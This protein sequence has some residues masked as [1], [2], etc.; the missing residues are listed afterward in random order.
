MHTDDQSPTA[1]FANLGRRI[2][3]RLLALYGVEAERATEQQIYAAISS[4]LRE[5][6]MRGWAQ[7]RRRHDAGGQRKVYY[8]SVEFLIGRNLNNA[9]CNLGIEDEIRS[10]LEPLGLDYD[11]LR[12]IEH[13]PGLGNGGLGRLAA[14]FLDSM[15]T[16]GLPGFGYGIRYDYGIF[17]Q[18]IGEQGEQTESPSEWLKFRNGWEVGRDDLRYTVPFGGRLTDDEERRWVDP[19]LVTAQ[20]Y[21]TPIPGDGGETVNYLRLWSGTAKEPFDLELFNAGRFEEAVAAQIEAKNLSRVLYP[22]DST[23]RG[24]ELRVRQQYFFVSASLQDILAK[25]AALGHPPA[26]LHHHAA[27]QLND[28]HPALAIPEL[29]RLLMD[30][31]GMDWD[32]AWEVT[33]QVFSYTNHTLLP[34][35]LES[36]PVAFFERLLPRHL[37][38]IYRINSE[39]LA[40]VDARFGAGDRRHRDMSLIEEGNGRRVRMS[41]L[42]IVGS[43]AVNGVAELHS[44]LMRETIFRDFYELYPD[45]FTNVTNGITPRRWLRQA[46]P[47]LSSLISS[48]IGECG[49]QRDLRLLRGLEQ[50]LEESEFREQFRAV[51]LA[52]K[53]RLARFLGAELEIAVDPASLF[54]AQI[55][56]IHEY[57]RQLLNL[58]HVIHRYNRIR[59]GRTEGMVPRTVIFSGKAA[60][61]YVMAKKIVQLINNVARQ[62]NADPLARD[63]LR[64]VFVPDY[65]VSWAERII[66]AANLSEQIST[67]GMEASGTGNMK[68]ALNGALTI[69]TLDGANIEIKDEVGEEN[70][71][72]FGLTAEE[73][74]AML[75]E[76]Y[77]P[78]AYLERNPE[79][80][81]VLKQIAGGAFAG[82]GENYADIVRS[83]T[84]HNE[85]YMILAD[86]DSYVAAQTRVDALFTEP[87]DWSR[88]AVLN[89]ARVGR[90]SSDRTVSEY[91]ER[92]WKTA[93]TGGGSSGQADEPR[94][95]GGRG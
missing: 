7:T 57:K 19:W 33:R 39:F 90:F 28:T 81:E 79:L 15:A 85:R 93:P 56:R 69:G 91:A 87:D 4:A 17:T 71:F 59:A 64:V 43:H 62:V 82:N 49:W 27:I 48:C 29:M 51:K 11:R 44:R 20:A 25:E 70:I 95:A 18:G 78:G 53:E 50:H 45:R 24:R 88:R 61:A 31:H 47:G 74:S 89:T 65:D 40:T 16:I 46:N 26:E 21:D 14:C 63:W 72:I 42:A 83:L 5:S 80:T 8:F 68:F 52:N 86:F 32:A 35:A 3:A 23:E 34:E 37:D 54:D 58:L 73:V 38:I 41:H 9:V 1:S 66:P 94:A 36:W 2:R 76:G 67:A 77:D 13:D 84:S 55:K 10:F 30:E 75:R 12:L 22:D 92:I 60:P 6:M